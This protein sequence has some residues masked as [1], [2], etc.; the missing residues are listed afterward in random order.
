M[1]SLLTTLNKKKGYTIMNNNQIAMIFVIF[2]VS[3]F[4]A[5][6]VSFNNKSLVDGIVTFT[7]VFAIGSKVVGIV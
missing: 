5:G 4:V 7:I 2:F 3:S 6:Y 1:R